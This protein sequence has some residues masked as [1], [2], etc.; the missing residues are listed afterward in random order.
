MTAFTWSVV[1]GDVVSVLSINNG[2][3]DDSVVEPW[4]T[5]SRCVII[6]SAAA[7][8][9]L[10]CDKVTGDCLAFRMRLM[11][12]LNSFGAKIL[13]SN[14]SNSTFVAAKNVKQL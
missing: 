1:N 11:T 3:V 6:A 13:S 2:C 10:G 4:K 9:P 7:S 5:C 8:G 12:M 14:T